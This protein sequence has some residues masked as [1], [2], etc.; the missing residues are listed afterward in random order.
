M[1]KVL[2]G[3]FWG[4]IFIIGA[5]YK[6]MTCTKEIKRAFVLHGERW[7]RIEKCFS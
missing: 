6:F 7:Y 2:L 3:F 5:I 4:M 1:K